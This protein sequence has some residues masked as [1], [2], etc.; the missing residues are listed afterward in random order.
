MN[1]IIEKPKNLSAGA[2]NVIKEA[3][4]N[5]MVDLKTLTH[6]TS[7]DRKLLNFVHKI[8]QGSETPK[9]S[10]RFQPNLPNDSVY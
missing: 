1:H 6:K 10:L 8:T 2:E 9:N 3:E 7:V 4:I 5:F